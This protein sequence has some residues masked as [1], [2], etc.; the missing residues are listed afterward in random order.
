MPRFGRRA[1]PSTEPEPADRPSGGAPIIV[2]ELKDGPLKG[3]SVDVAP[4]CSSSVR[5][6]P[7]LSPANCPSAETVVSSSPPCRVSDTSGA[8]IVS[9][10]PPV[11]LLEV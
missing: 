8:I 11:A 5:K 4:V 9:K 6:A 2:A 10:L 1:R 7:L 3:R